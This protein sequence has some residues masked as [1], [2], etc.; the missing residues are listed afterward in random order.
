MDEANFV[1]APGSAC[2]SNPTAKTGPTYT[3]VNYYT[4]NKGSPVC[5]R[6][7]WWNCQFGFYCNTSDTNSSAW[8]QGTCLVTNQAG[9]IGDK[10]KN[11][12]LTSGGQQE[13]YWGTGCS[14]FTNNNSTS[15]GQC[16]RM[17]NTNCEIQ[18]RNLVSCIQSNK[19]PHDGAQLLG[20]NGSPFTAS[21][22]VGSCIQIQCSQAHANL[23]KCQNDINSP[24]SIVSPAYIPATFPNNDYSNGSSGLQGWEIGLII[25]GI[26]VAIII[27]VVIV[28]AIVRRK[29][30]TAYQPLE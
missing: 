12:P 20:G 2:V 3:C 6:D 24:N 28:V 1:C 29:S 4:Q 30:N 19:C 27:I 5:Y 22:V 15:Q 8:A 17:Y 18:L 23:I 10:C 14:C 9:A 25:V 26:A 11:F 16:S 7:A 13:C 21:T